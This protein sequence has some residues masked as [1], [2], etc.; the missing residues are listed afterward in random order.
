ME[1]KG[2]ESYHLLLFL[3]G[4]LVA[5]VLDFVC[6]GPWSFLFC[7]FNMYF[8]FPQKSKKTVRWNSQAYRVWTIELKIIIRRRKRK[9]KQ[10]S[11]LDHK[12]EYCHNNHM[13]L[14]TLFSN[15]IPWP[16]QR[17][18]GPLK[19]ESH[20]LRSHIFAFKLKKSESHY[21]NV[22][23][24]MSAMMPHQ[25]LV[26]FLLVTKSRNRTHSI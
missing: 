14:L 23:N 18:S 1:V 5:F 2:L 9:K 25:S 3:F 22:I 20:P 4:L 21:G 11:K 13:K 24:I 10:G 19:D 7:F 26:G 15:S 12:S 6:V 17:S 16:T 8:H